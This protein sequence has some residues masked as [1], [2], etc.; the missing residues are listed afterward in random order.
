MGHSIEWGTNLLYNKYIEF[1]S[2]DTNHESAQERY[3]MKS[4]KILAGALA[5]SLG[6][7]VI[8]GVPAQAEPQ[9]YPSFTTTAQMVNLARVAADD[10][11]VTLRGAIGDYFRTH[12]GEAHFGE[13]LADEWP[14]E[15][16]GAGQQFDNGYIIYWSPQTGAFAVDFDGAIGDTYRQGDYESTYGYPLFDEVNIPGGAMQKFYKVG[17]GTYAFYWSP[18]TGPHTVWEGGAIGGRFTSEGGTGT[19]GFPTGEEEVTPYGAF[20]VFQ[21]GG[22][23]NR[24]YWSANTGTHVMKG[25][26]GIYTKWQAQGGEDRFGYPVTDEISESG[27]VVQYF[28]TSGGREYGIWWHPTYGTHTMNSKGA[29]YN[30]WFKAGNYRTLGY[31]TSDETTHADGSATISFSSGAQLKWTA[32]GGVQRIR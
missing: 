24:I 32:N 1:P 15:D 8:T 9:Q 29:L 20:Q 12:G 31:P 30:F 19:F 28:R 11:E 7:A 25:N 10:Y 17:K 21:Q 23:Q 26:G 27:A 22:V 18:S 3:N 4:P 5:L 6:A 16:G 2:I 13:P 14:L